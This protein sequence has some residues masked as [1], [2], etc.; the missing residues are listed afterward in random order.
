[1][2]TNPEAIGMRPRVD[3][4]HSDFEVPDELDDIFD[5]WRYSWTSSAIQRHP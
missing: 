4:D 3:A 1:L 5:I 2:Y